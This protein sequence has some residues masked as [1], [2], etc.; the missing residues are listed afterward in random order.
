MHCNNGV[1]LLISLMLDTKERRIKISSQVKEYD[2]IVC[3]STA[4][5]YTGIL[6]KQVPARVVHERQM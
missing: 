5:Y 6:L 4:Q 3:P 2:T 1:V